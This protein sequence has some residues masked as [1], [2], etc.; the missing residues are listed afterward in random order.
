MTDSELRR[1][2]NSHAFTAATLSAGLY[3]HLNVAF[4]NVQDGIEMKLPSP[5]SVDENV[6][7]II[8]ARYVIHATNFMLDHLPSLDP[9]RDR[10]D[11][12]KGPSVFN[13]ERWD[14]WK[15]RFDELRQNKELS[16]EARELARQAEVAMGKAERQ[17]RKNPKKGENGKKSGMK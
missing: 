13:L 3:D 6:K 4:W 11:L 12:W 7:I 5:I 2:I 17:K 8:A 1:F 16:D 9:R 15:T 10:S 14:M